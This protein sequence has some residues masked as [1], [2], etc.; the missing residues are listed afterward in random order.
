MVDI[1]GRMIVEV[2][3]SNDTQTRAFKM[4]EYAIPTD[5]E[6]IVQTNEILVQRAIMLNSDD[7]IVYARQCREFGAGYWIAKNGLEVVVVYSLDSDG[8]IS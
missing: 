1:Y 4:A 8:K 5:V 3:E 2:R 6:T 7:A